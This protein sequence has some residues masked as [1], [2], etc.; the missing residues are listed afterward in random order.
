[1]VSLD[2]DYT[3]PYAKLRYGLYKMVVLGSH[4]PKSSLTEFV[5][6]FSM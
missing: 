2:T 6:I 3:N 5:L 4:C 1:M